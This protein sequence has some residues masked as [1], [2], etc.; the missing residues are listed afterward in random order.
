VVT[1]PEIVVPEEKIMTALVPVPRNQR[2]VLK[3]RPIGDVAAKLLGEIPQEPAPADFPELP[4]PLTAPKEIRDALRTL[5]QTFN[6]TVVKE[7]RTLT[8]DEIAAVGKEYEALQKVAKLLTTREEQ[9]KEIV[10]TH[11][12]VEAEEKGLAHPKD[13]MLNGNLV[14]KATERDAKGHYVLASKGHPQETE[15]PGTTLKFSNQFSSGSVSADLGYITRAYKD[16]EI[17]EATY[18]AC[19]V[20]QRVPDADKVKQYVLRTGNVGLL[21]KIVKRGRNKSALY[22]RALKR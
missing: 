12:D 1:T 21:G 14:A 2:I 5:S 10:R 13:V 4:V 17:D 15:I 11:Q 9:V 16:G 6:G 3:D 22:L 18:K 20:V 19:T 7:R 8:E